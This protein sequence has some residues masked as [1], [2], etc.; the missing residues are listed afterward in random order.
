M[1]KKSKERASLKILLRLRPYVRPYLLLMLLLVVVTLGFGLSDAGRAMLAKPLL[2][3]VFARGGEV[4]GQLADEAYLL[5]LEDRVGNE[6]LAKAKVPGKGAVSVSRRDEI[7]RSPLLAGAASFRTDERLGIEPLLERTSEA[8]LETADD[9]PPVPADS[10]ETWDLLSR[11]VETQLLA[12]QAHRAG[13][14]ARA[15]FLSIEARRLAHDAGFLLAWD[16]LWWVFWAA[17]GF[18]IALAATNYWMLYLSRAIAARVFVDLQ[19]QMAAHLLTLSVRFFERERRGDLLGRL[20]IDLGHTAN[21]FSVAVD[22]VVRSL[23]LAILAIWA[24]WIS[25]ELACVIFVLGGLFVVPLRLLGRKIRRNARKRQAMTGDTVEVMQQLL[26]G[27]REVKT[28]QREEHETKR[29]RD[30]SGDVLGA[31]I[32][33]LKARAASKA[34]MQLFNDIAIPV[35]FC[36]GSWLVV[37]RVFGVDV[38]TFATFLGM[39]LLMYQPAKILGES[40]NTLMDAL[41]ALERVFQLFDQR[42]EVN[43]IDEPQPFEVLQESVSFN[44]LAFSYDGQHEV[45]HAIDFTAPAGSTTALVGATGSGKSTLVDL[46]A[47]Y[48]DPTQGEVRFD[49]V[50]LSKLRL[51]DVLDRLA[52]VPQ[53]NFLFNDTLRENIRYGRLD[54]SDEEV[55][56]AARL[57]EVHDEI[58]ALPGGYEYQAGE[59]GDRLSGGQVQRIAIARAILKKPQLLILDEATSALDNQTEAKVQIAIDRLTRSCTTFVIAHRLST[60]RDADQI[61]VLSEGRI[62]ERGSHDELVAQ[63]GAYALLV[64]E[65]LEK[66]SGKGTVG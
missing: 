11:G 33:T 34:W 5:T 42:P 59:R 62:V 30:V 10:P 47:R 58:V 48:A 3:K 44:D 40:Y 46:V 53:E 32:R 21:L 55:E 1:S 13:L 43:D 7:A 4:K 36:I 66:P 63:G 15:A 45:L 18:A 57:A 14:D 27:M 65:Q 24:L 12:I 52:V 28:F 20:T 51:T 16:T 9:L 17:I 41:P 54:A 56:E 35:I 31:Q 8:L 39:V 64:K 2:N 37:N 49:G 60:V 38:G 29:F 61:L 23:H 26:G 6:A 22:V 19:N 25:V 50:P